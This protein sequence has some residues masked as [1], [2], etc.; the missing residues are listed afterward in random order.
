M[1]R[2]RIPFGS[3]RHG[4]ALL[5]GAH[6]RRCRSLLV[7]DR[8]AFVVWSITALR[9]PCW[10]R[11]AHAGRHKFSA[12]ACSQLK[13]CRYSTVPENEFS[14]CRLC[15]GGCSFQRK[16]LGHEFPANRES[17]SEM[18]PFRHG[19]WARCSAQ[20]QIPSGMQGLPLILLPNANRKLFRPYRERSGRYQGMSRESNFLAILRFE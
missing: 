2:S 8:I 19:L 6:G 12:P 17:N 11:K 3:R 7:M 13:L 18:S 4:D 20:S 16:R 1:A 15:G 14:S 5:P 10:S 9:M